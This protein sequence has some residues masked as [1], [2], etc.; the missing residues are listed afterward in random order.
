MRHGENLRIDSRLFLNDLKQFFVHGERKMIQRFD[1][2]GF[3]GRVQQSKC[4]ARSMISDR[5]SF[6]E[7]DAQIFVTACQTI[8]DRRADDSSA[9]NH[10]VTL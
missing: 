9:N 2:P 4:K 8:C 5:I 6:D 1:V 7:R 10:N 3:V